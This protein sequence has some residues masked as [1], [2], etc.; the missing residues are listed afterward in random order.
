MLE[1]SGLT[2][3]FGGLKA[4]NNVY[5]SI[6]RREIHGLIGPNGSGKTTLINVVTGFYSPTRGEVRFKGN[7][8]TGAPPYTIAK[9]GMVRT[10][11]NINLFPEMTALENVITGHFFQIAP[12]LLS[13]ILRSPSY[14]EKEAKARNLGNEILEFVGL[15]PDRD[16]KA[17][18]L[19]YGK[20][21]VLEIA[22][23]LMTFPQFLVLDEP[24]AGMNDQESDIVSGLIVKLRDER[25]ITVL[26]IEHHMRFVMNL[27]EKIT[28]LNA[29]GVIARG[30][31]REIQN[32]KEVI[33]VY[34]GTRRE[35]HAEDR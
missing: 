34:L 18:N 30:I 4:L 32:N 7:D 28:V 5:L 15:Y 8:V 24:V 17:R 23:A 14:R 1:V 25:D 33:D 21:R 12:S 20:Q 9:R 19:P 11:Q 16:M 29:G 2:M 6:G 26:L 10:F 13:V 3:A 22:R 31:P 27:C 35:K